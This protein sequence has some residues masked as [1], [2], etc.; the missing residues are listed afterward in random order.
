MF[1]IQLATW[2]E[3][4]LYVITSV[5]KTNTKQNTAGESTRRK[6]SLEDNLTFEGHSFMVCKKLFVATVGMSER[7]LMH[8]LDQE[9]K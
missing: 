9:I 3:R 5:K 1:L 8:W 7:T 6:Y 4:K 2:T